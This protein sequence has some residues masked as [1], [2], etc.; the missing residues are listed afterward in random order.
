MIEREIMQRGDNTPDHRATLQNVGRFVP[1]ALKWVIKHGTPRSALAE[2]RWTPELAAL[3]EEAL[4]LAHD[5]SHF[6]T[7]FPMWHRDRNWAELISPTLVQLSA[8]GTARD[9]TGQRI[10]KGFQAKGRFVQ[11]GARSEGEPQ[12]DRNGIIRYRDTDGKA[13][14][15]SILRIR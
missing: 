13:N 5:Y 6:E 8:P 12:Q 14:R 11:G 3:A 1:I 4:Y 9:K 10:P 2:R 15:H 7:C